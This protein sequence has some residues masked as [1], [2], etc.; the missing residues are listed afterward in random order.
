M[1][2]SNWRPMLPPFRQF[3]TN[4]RMSISRNSSPTPNWARSWQPTSRTPTSKRK[5]ET[6]GS[7]PW[8]RCRIWSKACK[9][10][11]RWRPWSRISSKPLT[12]GP[13]SAARS[14][15][16]SSKSWPKTASWPLP[17]RIRLSQPSWPPSPTT[18]PWRTSRPPSAKLPARR[19][20]NSSRNTWTSTT[21]PG[22]RTWTR[23]PPKR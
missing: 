6:S 5:S 2:K 14:R 10:K 9:T 20:P 23:Q 19:P 18:R 3:Q 22:S 21:K 12:S 11:R 1:R 8:H 4:W 16:A 13:K 17:W 15:K 7:R